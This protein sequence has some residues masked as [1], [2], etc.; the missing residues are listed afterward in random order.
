[1][2]EKTILL[3][4]D[5]QEEITLMLRALRKNNIRSKMVIVRNGA[6][7]LD[8]LFCQ[9]EYADRNPKDLPQLVLLDINLPKISGLDVLR[10]LRADARTSLLPIVMLTASKEEKDIKEAFKNGA[11]SYVWKSID[12][13]EFI[14]SV[15]QLHSYWL[16]LNQS[17]PE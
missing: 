16:E 3:V 10:R 11:N 17:P 12:Y 13:D 2:T 6:E 1:M 14:E 15:G 5:N 7:A 8:Y 4:E 9:N